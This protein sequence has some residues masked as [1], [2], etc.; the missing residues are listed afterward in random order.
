MVKNRR[1]IRTKAC[2]SGMWV[3]V[4]GR[5]LHLPE[6]FAAIEKATISYPEEHSQGLQH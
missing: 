4:R 1:G 2:E 6:T 5:S 3:H